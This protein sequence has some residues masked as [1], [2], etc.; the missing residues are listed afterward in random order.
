VLQARLSSP[1]D[2]L[3]PRVGRGIVQDVPVLP[4]DQRIV[5]DL[6][7]QSS[8]IVED[9]GIQSSEIV[10]DLGDSEFRVGVRGSGLGIWV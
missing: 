9:L 6:G 8:E 1:Y 3:G 7:I 4:G 10:E 2:A 5:E